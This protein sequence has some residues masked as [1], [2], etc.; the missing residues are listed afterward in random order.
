M[1]LINRKNLLS[2][3][4]I[5]VRMTGLLYARG[6]I[7]VSTIYV[8]R[9]VG[10][11][12]FGH[13]RIVLSL[14]NLLS[15]LA[16]FPMERVVASMIAKFPKNR[17][18]ILIHSTIFLLIIIFGSILFFNLILRIFN[19]VNDNIALELFFKYSPFVFAYVLS[20]MLI[21]YLQGAAKIKAMTL[22][23][24]IY[25]TFKA[26]SIIGF[27]FFFGYFGW[28][29]GRVIGEVFSFLCI[30]VIAVIIQKKIIADQTFKIDFNL[31]KTLWKNYL[32]RLTESGLTAIQTNLDVFLV[33][34]FVQDIKQIAYIG[35]A[36]MFLTSFGLFGH[37]ITS[38]L[39]PSIAKLYDNKKR[40]LTKLKKI[41]FTSNLVFIFILVPFFV[42][43]EQIIV[44]LYKSEYIEATRFLKIFII[45]AIFQNIGFI[46]GGF[47]L[48]IGNVKLST[49]FSII[50]FIFYTLL[51]IIMMYFFD[52]IGI[53]IAIL[54]SKIYS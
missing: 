42:F 22:G 3:S 12:N 53:V 48:A 15:I 1:R 13:I 24:I 19:L 6:I 51:S 25:G 20:Y 34:W 32:Y 40:F 35:A 45:A 27:V 14:Y 49:K 54:C 33:M 41:Q 39:F 46:N 47:W 11:E 16:G 21:A 31:F 7:L 29:K 44:L 5:S 26:L 43:A 37:S 4:N 17:K 9:T 50:S 23:E 10:P 2:V 28:L 8:A 36:K 38:G 52:V 18:N 30:I